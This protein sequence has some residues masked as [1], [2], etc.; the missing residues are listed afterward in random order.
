MTKKFLM[1]A[2]IL[3]CLCGGAFSAVT[4]TAEA[5]D[6]VTDSS[7]EGDNII[8][9]DPAYTVI[10]DENVKMQ[11]ESVQRE[12]YNEGMGVNE[13]ITYSV[14]LN[15]ENKNQEHDVDCSVSVDGAYIDG[16]T[17]VFG[18]DTMKTKAGKKND[19]ARYTCTIYPENPQASS[20]GS[21]HIT[22]LE[23]LL[24]FEASVNVTLSD[25]TGDAI[26]IADRYVVDISLEDQ[27]A[28]NTENAESAEKTEDVEETSSLELVDDIK[29]GDTR[30]Q[31]NEKLKTAE[32]CPK[33]RTTYTSADE[34]FMQGYS[35]ESPES[36]LSFKI[37]LEGYRS[38]ITCVYEGDEG[39]LVDLHASVAGS[40]DES[41]SDV[42]AGLQTKITDKYGEP[43]ANADIEHR[44]GTVGFAY[45]EFVN[46]QSY[47]DR[48]VEVE[49]YSEWN[50]P[51][52]NAKIELFQAKSGEH[53]YVFIDYRD[54]K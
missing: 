10:D 33:M 39:E 2:G 38:S 3:G 53:E 17:V 8:N 22:S 11:I 15:I 5:E 51:E 31:V 23:D 21:E 32:N 27:I 18:N 47:F 28:E 36:E 34:Y 1:M 41:Y 9:F 50:L 43:V 4:V 42:F 12:S 37:D 29:F 30:E 49:N 52:Y 54:Q 40:D 16:Y 24:T 35:S 6:T 25:N 20:G 7:A 45:D 13:F 46:L 19:A 44:S 26:L 14:N 48:T